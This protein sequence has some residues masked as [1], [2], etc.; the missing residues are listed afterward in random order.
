MNSRGWTRRSW[1]VVVG[2]T[3]LVRS[4]EAAPPA[5]TT[6][7]TGEPAKASAEE[8]DPAVLE[9][10]R[11]FD[12]G[13]EAY[14]LGRFDVAVENF[15]RAYELSQ[16]NA[17]LFNIAQ[18]YTK[19]FDV[20]P[21]P[22]HLRKAKVMFLNF[23]KIAEAS[24]EDPRDARA[25]MA[26]IDEQLADFEAQQEAERARAE[27]A[28][29]ERREAETRRLEAEAKL[30]ASRRYKPRTLGAVGWS[31]LG[32]GFL[33]GWT[34]ASIGTVSVRRLNEQRT[35]EQGLPLTAER[36]ALY[37]LNITKA[38]L[39]NGF[40]IGIGFVLVVSGITM[41]TVDAVRGK[42]AA[43]RAS[44]VPGGLVVAF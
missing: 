36:E 34:V 21:N 4:A 10:Q 26:K 13:A 43:R 7:A 27:V 16:A 29:K 41:I 40:G 18:A 38:N 44:L 31:L 32:V 5:P 20:D 30:A 39:V 6:A 3:L 11:L 24:G 23:A 25:R 2:S 9:A 37:D 17:L 12:K 8:Q 35:A 1:A 42:R 14:N 33:G 22:A 19:Y 15:E 28:E